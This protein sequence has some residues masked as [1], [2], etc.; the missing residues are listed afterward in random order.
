[1]VTDTDLERELRGRDVPSFAPDIPAAVER[2]A[3]RPWQGGSKVKRSA[4]PPQPPTSC[5]RAEVSKYRT[6]GT[7]RTAHS[8]PAPR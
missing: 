5:G 1:M 2:G 6:C 3:S 7:Q 8:R 4:T